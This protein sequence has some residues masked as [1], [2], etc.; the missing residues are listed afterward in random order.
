MP[1]E[2]RHMEHVLATIVDKNTALFND[3]AIAHIEHSLAG[4]EFALIGVSSHMKT[5]D[6]EWLILHCGGTLTKNVSDTTSFVIKGSRVGDTMHKHSENVEDLEVYKDA[7][8]KG[9][10]FLST[11]EFF[12]LVR[13]AQ[14]KH[15]IE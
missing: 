9:T 13:A 7:V 14:N 10:L 3:S 12:K 8:S 6:L 1:V 4:S 5:I 11:L 15:N 2:T